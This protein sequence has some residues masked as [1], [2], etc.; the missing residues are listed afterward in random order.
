MKSMFF[1]LTVMICLLLISLPLFGQNKQVYKHPRLDIQI[2]VPSG[3]KQL[4][5][6]ADPSIYEIADPEKFVHVMLWYTAT[7]QDAKGYLEK[8][9]DMKGL[10]WEGKPVAVEGREDDAWVV[11]ATGIVWRMNARV[12]LTV[13]H[14]GYDG[15]HVDHNA[16]YIVMIWCPE[17]DFSRHK[18]QMV[19]ILKS[20]RFSE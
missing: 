15:R 9:A 18:L 13:I 1:L 19:D 4:Q 16:L 8:M 14:H 5:R 12:L 3:W 10:H 11:D 6:H 2:E 7:M 17:P 20:V